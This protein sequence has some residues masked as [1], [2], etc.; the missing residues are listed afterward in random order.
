[1]IERPAYLK[2]A[3]ELRAGIRDGTHPPGSK[4]PS[5]RALAAQHGV[6][7]IVIRAA[8]AVLRNEGLVTTQAR[9]RTV[10]RDHPPVRWRIAAERYQREFRHEA[11]DEPKTSF[12]ADQGI[13][14]EQ[15]RLDKTFQETEA[16]P[17]L[18]ALFE[19]E[20]GTMLL[21]R[22]FVFYA[23]GEPQQMSRTY[24]PLELVSGTPVAD[25]QNEPWPGGTPA[26]L[27]SLGHPLTRLEESVKAR[28]PTPEEVQTLRIAAGIPVF[29]ITRRMI[30]EGQVLEVAADIVIPADQVIL[31]YA[32]DLHPSPSSPA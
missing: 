1:M 27:A 4:L 2:V 26:Q 5:L 22:R 21:Q 29:S 15:Y 17:E 25:P 13:P 24:L 8:F 6:S 19:V 14:W 30:S 9:S 18:A 3:D 31:D 12:T 20:P 23:G 10:V 7:E 28:M 11:T 16:T 32:I